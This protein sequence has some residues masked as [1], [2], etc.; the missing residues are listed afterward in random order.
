MF[1]IFLCKTSARKRAVNLST[2]FSE[3]SFDVSQLRNIKFYEWENISSVVALP[4]YANESYS[5]TVYN[6]ATQK[7]ETST[8]WRLVQNGTVQQTIY[9]MEWKP[10]KMQH[11]ERTAK[12]YK[13]NMG[14]INLGKLENQVVQNRVRCPI[15]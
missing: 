13:E 14:S 3:I 9:T 6:N 5:C 1:I 10:A 8:C 4:T 2:I 12:V 15:H 11:F 7:N